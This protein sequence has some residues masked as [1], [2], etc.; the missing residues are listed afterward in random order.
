MKISKIQTRII[1]DSRKK[2][3][4]EVQIFFNKGF[5]VFASVPKGTSEGEKEAIYLLPQKAQENIQKIIQPKL[6]DREFSSQKDFDNFLIDLDGTKDKSGLGANAILALSLAFARGIAKARDLELYQYLSQLANAKPELPSFYINL[7]EGGKHAEN[8]PDWQEYLA[9]VKEK[10]AQEQL[11]VSN[12]LFDHLGDLLR[13]QTEILKNGYEGGYDLEIKDCL[14]PINLI[15]KTIEGLGLRDRVG[16]ALD[17]AANSFAIDQGNSY[18]VSEKRI[19]VKELTNMYKNVSSKYN[20]ISIEDPYYEN[21]I[22][23]YAT[24]N[25]SLDSGFVVGDDLTVTQADLI[26]KAIQFNA[27]GGVVIKPNQVG[28]LTEV[29]GAI[30]VAKENNIKIIVSH[31]SGETMDDFIADLAYGVGAYGLKSGSPEPQERLVKYQRII[32]IES[33]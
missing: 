30:K 9:V 33:S 19:E 31:R 4:I 6:I 8:G 24:L 21:K 11:E 32:E 14:K 3:T 17:V 1:K 23:D 27:I 22:E 12:N 7:I 13:N 2:D 28:S 29:I 18:Q 25:Q 20:L 10:T 15:N 16:V 5:S 26:K